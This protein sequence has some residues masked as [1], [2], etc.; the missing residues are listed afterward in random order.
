MTVCGREGEV[1]DR[2]RQYSQGTDR[3][4]LRIGL[5]GQI[6]MRRDDESRDYFTSL[7]IGPTGGEDLRSED[8]GFSRHSTVPK[9]E[10]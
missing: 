1:R 6:R 10:P 9:G 4:A 2:K 5:Q 3:Q 7:R 8:G